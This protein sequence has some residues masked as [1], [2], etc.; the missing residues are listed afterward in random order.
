MTPEFSLDELETPRL[1]LRKLA[2]YDAEQLALL[3]SDERVNRYLDRPASTSHEEA[4]QFVNKILY[5]NSYYW[6]INRKNET[7]LIG[8]VCLWNFDHENS[9]VEIGY[10]LFPQFHGEGL[11]MEVIPAIIAYNSTVLQFA[12]IIGTTHIENIS[13]INL[14]K[15][16]N[17]IR[18][19]TRENQFHKGGGSSH[20]IVY[21]LNTYC[22]SVHF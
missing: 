14:L 5:S 7:K 12:T 4:V 3:R 1:R 21:S 22:P 17:F 20:E 2:I 8:T 18:D 11:M 6:A 15:K 10:E 13:S 16:N 19:E 9:V